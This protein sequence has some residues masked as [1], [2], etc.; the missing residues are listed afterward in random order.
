MLR[1][2]SKIFNISLLSLFYQWVNKQRMEKKFMDDNKGTS[3]T[4][5][6]VNALESIYFTWA[7][8]KGQHSWNAKYE[9]L[10]QYFQENGHANVP[11]KY[12]E[13]KALGRWVSTQRSQYK[14]MFLNQPSHMT[15]DRYNKLTALGFSFDMLNRKEEEDDVH[16]A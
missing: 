7:K 16:S 3:M 11:T 12:E 4:R 14:Q 10:A 2:S 8:R 1:I 15:Q 9:Q 13:N 6:R 5:D